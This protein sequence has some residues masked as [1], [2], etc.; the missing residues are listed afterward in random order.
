MIELR[1]RGFESSRGQSSEE[2]MSFSSF[3]IVSSSGKQNF[4]VG[5]REDG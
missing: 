3:V 5:K 2:L 1:R 4:L